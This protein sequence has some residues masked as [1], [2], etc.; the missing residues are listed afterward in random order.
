MN[1]KRKLRYRIK[2]II[3]DRPAVEATKIRNRLKQELGKDGKPWSDSQLSQYINLE[4]TD[5][6]DF[7]GEQLNI[8]AG[9]LDC[10]IAELYNRKK[11][12]A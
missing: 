2:A 3:E 11:A 1:A 10:G 5:T 7:K 8:I 9:V 12:T 6:R 4:E